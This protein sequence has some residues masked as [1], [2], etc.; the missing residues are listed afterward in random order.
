MKIIY[1]NGHILSFIIGI[2]FC[3][4]NGLGYLQIL[5]LKSLTFGFMVGNILNSI[6]QSASFKGNKNDK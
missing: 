5:N 1:K 6:V 3:I 4:I 2:Y